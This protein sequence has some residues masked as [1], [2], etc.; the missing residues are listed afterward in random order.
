MLNGDRLSSF[1]VI[2]FTLHS[3]HF[4]MMGQTMSFF[5]NTYLD[6]CIRQ[7]LFFSLYIIVPGNLYIRNMNCIKKRL[8]R[9]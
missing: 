2:L 5:I 1:H 9:F 3:V 8:I 6:L 4:M 7:S